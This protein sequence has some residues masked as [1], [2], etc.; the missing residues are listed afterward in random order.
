MFNTWDGRDVGTS[1]A[2][3][4]DQLQH[5]ASI[6][7]KVENPGSTSWNGGVHFELLPGRRMSADKPALRLERWRLFIG[8]GSRLDPEIVIGR[9]PTAS[10]LLPGEA[11]GQALS[12]ELKWR[13]PGLRTCLSETLLKGRWLG[14]SFAHSHELQH[15]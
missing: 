12:S 5:R 1:L 10:V 6:P 15:E 13:Y 3:R 2:H 9:T 14:L 8:E 4:A 7:P 11:D